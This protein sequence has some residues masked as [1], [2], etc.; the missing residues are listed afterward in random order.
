M[1]SW[2]CKYLETLSTW[3]LERPHQALSRVGNIHYPS[4][5]SLW[6]FQQQ[7][8]F[9]AFPLTTPQFPG[10]SCLLAGTSLTPSYGPSQLS[11]LAHPSLF[12]C[13]SCWHLEALSH[14]DIWWQHQA[15]DSGRQVLLSFLSSIMISPS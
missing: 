14:R 9:D 7:L 1:G 6:F 5:P 12:F 11:L 13:V 15:R 2:G 10:H 4:R 8:I 3:D